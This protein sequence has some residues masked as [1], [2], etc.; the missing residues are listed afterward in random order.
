MTKKWEVVSAEG[1]VL[2]NATRVAFWAQVWGLTAR[3]TATRLASKSEGQ[4]A[5][6]VK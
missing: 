2:I 5:R 6:V 4:K 1:S 3:T